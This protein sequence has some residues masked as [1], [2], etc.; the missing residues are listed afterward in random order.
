MIFNYVIKINEVKTI[1]DNWK[2][3]Y[4]IGQLLREFFYPNADFTSLGLADQR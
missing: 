3:N 1:I 4:P 2:F